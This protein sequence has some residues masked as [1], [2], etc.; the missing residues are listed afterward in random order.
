VAEELGAPHDQLQ[1]Q[2]GT[3][4]LPGS[5]RHTTYWDLMGGRFFRYRVT[6]TAPP[7]S[8]AVHRIVGTG[9][10]A[11]GPTVAAIA[12][13]VANATRVRIRELPLTPARVFAALQQATAQPSSA[14]Q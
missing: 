4:T 2:D 5:Q 13:A 8:P 6:G 7:K 12:N 10:A 3:V 1:V 9:E 14:T 11:Q